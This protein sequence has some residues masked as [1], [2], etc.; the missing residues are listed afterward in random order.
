MWKTVATHTDINDENQT[1]HVPKIRTNAI[2]SETR[3]H[4]SKM[5]GSMT[6]IDT[7]SYENLIP[8]FT[9]VL[10]GYLMDKPRSDSTAVNGLKIK[11]KDGNYITNRIEFTPDKPNGSVQLHLQGNASEF[12]TDEGSFS[13]E[14]LVVF[15]RLYLKDNKDSSDELLIVANHEDINDE[16]QTIYCP[17]ISTKVAAYDLGEVTKDGYA[18]HVL[19]AVAYECDNCKTRFVGEL[20]AQAHIRDNRICMNNTPSGKSGYSSV[21][22]VTIYDMVHYENL[23]PN[24]TYSVV[25]HIIDTKTGES[26]LINQRQVQ[27]EQKYFTPGSPNGDVQVVFHVT[28]IDLAGGR[29]V[30]YEELFLDGVSIAKHKSFYDDNQTFY[31][32]RMATSV[33]DDN[34]KTNIIKSGTISTITDTVEISG[35]KE[36]Q[37]YRFFYINS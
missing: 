34:T 32:P 8:G 18:D 26:V 20:E 31:V 23:I 33:K 25:G 1:V 37:K 22:E 17:T 7:V 29:Y 13:S 12:Q 35:L 28:G 30:I 19:G 36:G 14:T 11:D 16:N 15:E 9:Y 10:E 4:T 6:I 27:S 21:T 2:D 24:R 3:T 5:D